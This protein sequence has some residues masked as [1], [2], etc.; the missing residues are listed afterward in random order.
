MRAALAGPVRSLGL[1]LLLAA[2]LSL[3]EALAH[4]FGQQYYGL[5]T[6]VRMTATGPE[7]VVAGEVPIQVVLAEFRRFFRGVVRPGP[8]EDA[9]YMERKLDQLRDGLELR[10]DGKPAEGA[11][12]NLDDPANGKAAEGAFTYFLVF[13]PAQAWALDGDSITLELSTAAYDGLPLWC[14]A[15]AGIKLLDFPGGR[16]GWTISENSARA[17]IG[18]AADDPDGATDPDGWSQDPAMRSWRVVYQRVSRVGADE[19]AERR[20]GCW[21]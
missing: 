3:P 8:A 5:R 20:W 14:S 9:A 11:W 15:F 6:Q 10:V 13:E 1:G 19:S 2:F 7:V 21:G 18:S 4:P 16:S 12:V 17:L